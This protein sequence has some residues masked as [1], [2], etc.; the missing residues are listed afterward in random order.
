M[1]KSTLLLSFLFLSTFA[2]AQVQRYVTI[3]HFTNS[4]CSICASRN[5][6]FYSLIDNYPGA[7]HHVAVHPSFPYNTCVFYLANTTENTNW[8]NTYSI[9]STPRVA[10]NGTMVPLGSQLLPAATLQ[11]A[12]NQTS[13]LYLQVSEPST[14]A[15]RNVTVTAR[16]EGPLSGNLRLFVAVLEKTINLTTSNG[17]AVHHDVFRHMLTPADGVAYTPAPLGGE[18]SFNFNYSVN[19][20]WNT[21]EVYVL[22]FVR[23]MDTKEIVNS[24]TRF[25]PIVSSTKQASVF[26]LVLTPNPTTDVVQLRLSNDNMLQSLQLYDLSGRE[27]RVPSSP[28]LYGAEIDVASLKNG[29]YL[30]RITTKQGLI[31]RKLIKN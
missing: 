17:E 30:L 26:P 24:G 28:T 29:I 9:G 19:A 25:D 4:K 21:D 6:A 15:N 1:K 31:T 3:E 8:V 18:T 12:L 2:F 27:I 11:A 5:P 7:I 14:G 20:G 16:T 13:N 10:L 23:D 22:A